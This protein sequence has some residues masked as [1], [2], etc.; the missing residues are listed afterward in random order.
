MPSAPLNIQNHT[1]VATGPALTRQGVGAFRQVLQQE[2]SVIPEHVGLEG[3]QAV[4]THECRPQVGHRGGLLQRLI[5]LGG[6]GPAQVAGFCP[7]ETLVHVGTEIHPVP[8]A[9]GAAGL[10]DSQV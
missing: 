5:L 1:E 4:L 6:E 2:G 3:Q 10:G 9:V 8:S 7:Q